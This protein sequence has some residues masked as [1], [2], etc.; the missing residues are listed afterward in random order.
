MKLKQL[1]VVSVF[2][3][4]VSAVWADSP[5][6]TWAL[7][8]G[9]TATLRVMNLEGGKVLFSNEKGVRRWV[10]LDLLVAEDRVRALATR[11]TDHVEFVKLQDATAPYTQPEPNRPEQA[12]NTPNPVQTAPV[13]TQKAPTPVQSAPTPVRKATAPHPSP[14]PI[15]H[16]PAQNSYGQRPMPTPIQKAGQ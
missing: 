3:L 7:S 13:P 2:S 4:W 16:A 8:D 5:Y 9:R 15:Q 14:T 6:S 10:P 11:R 1:A 12:P